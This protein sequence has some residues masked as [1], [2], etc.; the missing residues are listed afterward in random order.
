M[1]TV[2]HET[3]CNLLV[4]HE[5]RPHLLRK[6]S[7]STRVLLKAVHSGDQHLTQRILTDP[8]TQREAYWELAELCYDNPKL[9]ENALKLEIKDEAEWKLIQTITQTKRL[10]TLPIL[11]QPMTEVFFSPDNS[12]ASTTTPDV[13]AIANA[14]T[15]IRTHP[16]EKEEVVRML[17]AL[18]RGEEDVA[19]IDE[20]IRRRTAR[21]LSLTLLNDLVAKS[22]LVRL[23]GETI[24]VQGKLH[25]YRINLNTGSCYLNER[26][27]CI[28]PG[29]NGRSSGRLI[30]SDERAVE[31]DEG[32]L[33]TVAKILFLLQD[34]E[35]AEKDQ[36]F[37]KQV[38][39]SPE[40]SRA[41]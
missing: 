6:D 13:Y 23:E 34:D 16:S 15:T 12:I 22:P 2:I 10:D 8:H 36:V 35:N 17:C 38:K 14:E 37:G 9:R 39:P 21:E 30:L 7:A 40:E 18:L 31:A 41:N 33:L 24:R 19:V 27:L 25:E 1:K 3:H 4:I 20:W 29:Y 28:V 32:I 26:R 5:G 11:Y